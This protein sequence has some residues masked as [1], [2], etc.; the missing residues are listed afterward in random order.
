MF[1][2]GWQ[3][4]DRIKLV[5]MESRPLVRKILVNFLDK[6]EFIDLDAYECNEGFKRCVTEDVPDVIVANLMDMALIHREMKDVCRD[7]HSH[8]ILITYYD[9]ERDYIREI[10]REV[11]ADVIFN[12][13][14]LAERLAL[15]LNIFPTLM[16]DHREA[17]DMCRI[18]YPD[19]EHDALQCPKKGM[20]SLNPHPIIFMDDTDFSEF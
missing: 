17:A 20:S 6:Y 4:Q 8:A 7:I 18:I 12:N 13:G 10:A 1:D 16:A 5:L 11:G 15:V 14:D 9:N 2:R 19:D 3:F